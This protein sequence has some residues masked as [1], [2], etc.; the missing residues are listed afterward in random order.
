MNYVKSAIILFCILFFDNIFSK[1]QPIYFIHIPK[2]AGR[3]IEHIGFKKNILFGKNYRTPIL[4][5]RF[6]HN[7]FDLNY[8]NPFKSIGIIS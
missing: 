6:W 8:Y 7:P 4:G 2:T 1:K 5:I 3:T